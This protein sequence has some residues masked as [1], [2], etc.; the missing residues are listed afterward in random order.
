MPVPPSLHREQD[1][2]YVPP[3]QP[4]SAEKLET[5]R[6]RKRGA[7]QRAG[8][9]AGIDAVTELPDAV[10]KANIRDTS[11]IIG[12]RRYASAGGAA[13]PRCPVAAHTTWQ[14]CSRPTGIL[15]IDVVVCSY[16]YG[17]D[18]SC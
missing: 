9:G 11:D 2:Y 3:E 10:L 12:G 7:M 1:P 14:V 5:S 13:A 4:L 17:P 8:H 18:P 6:K 15:E 16:T